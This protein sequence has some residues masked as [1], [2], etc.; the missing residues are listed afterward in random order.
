MIREMKAVV[1]TGQS[2]TATRMNLKEDPFRDVKELE[3]N[4]SLVEAIISMKMEKPLFNA[5]P[6]EKESGGE[7]AGEWGDS[8]EVPA[9]RPAQI[10]A[11]PRG[12]PGVYEIFSRFYKLGRTG[13]G[14]SKRVKCR[15]Y[16]E[17]RSVT[18][19]LLIAHGSMRKEK[20]RRISFCHSLF[21]TCGV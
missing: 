5:F 4:K 17:S 7:G 18:L 13:A 16:D 12:L 10:N 8:K 15:Q 19:T 6:V 2:L 14:M 3:I 1:R 20:G 11:K 21:H 9:D